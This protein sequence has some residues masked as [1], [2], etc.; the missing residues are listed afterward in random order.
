[1]PSNSTEP[2]AALAELRELL[3]GQE[4]QDLA[5]VQARLAD[6]ARRA[7]D[8]AEALPAAL[9]AAKANSLRDALEPLIEKT[10]HSSVRNHPQKLVDA[11][12]PIMGPAIRTSIAASIR[13]FAESLNQ[14]VRKS[15]SFQSI[16]WRIEALITGK[17]FSDIL[18]S[19]SLLYSVEQVFLIHRQSG[20]LLQ[21][22][23]AQGSVLKDA[24]M[25][26]G[27]L[28]AIKIGRASCRERV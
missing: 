16:R 22:A 2:A 26:S 18:I 27:M 17:S 10:L 11:I 12:Y 6:P 20:L 23:A 1:M 9:K 8:L 4:L 15:F 24:D 5:D 13:E 14:I 21:H 7:A 28:T 25:I 19:R 3:V